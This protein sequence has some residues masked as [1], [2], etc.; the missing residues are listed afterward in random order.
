VNELLQIR[1]HGRG[2]QGV[3]TAAKLLAK[4]AI[5]ESKYVQ[6]FP[7]FGPE[8]AGAP[9]KGFNRISTSPIRIHCQIATP[10]VVVVLDE[11][12]IDSSDV[13]EGLEPGTLLII[14]T[15]RSQE[16]LRKAENLIPYKLFPVDATA[17]AIEAFGK[18][19]PNM[20]M[21]G[22]LAKVT[23][24]VGLETLLRTVESEFSARFKEQIIK[25]NLNAVKK[26][27]DTMTASH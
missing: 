24:V 19:I 9:V 12:L 26:A 8:R 22:A 14:N 20:P 15:A 5:Q 11:S 16:E 17:I 6:A 13:L 27:Y 4:V 18:N 21:L 3:V 25:G 23:G 10:N 7:E 2:G 1:W